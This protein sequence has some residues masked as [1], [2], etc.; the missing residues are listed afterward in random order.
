V[1]ESRQFLTLMS[2]YVLSKC[3]QDLY[4]VRLSNIVLK[5][6]GEQNCLIALFLGK[7]EIVLKCKRLMLKESF[8]PVWIRSPD[9][10]YCVYSLS[11]P[12]CHGAVPGDRT[13]SDFHVKLPKDVR[14]NMIYTEFLFLPHTCLELQAVTTLFGENYNQLD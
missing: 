9:I 7:M 8:E 12:T 5:C 2:P 6:A 1:A 13:S 14:W 3:K 11:T 10:N 4:T